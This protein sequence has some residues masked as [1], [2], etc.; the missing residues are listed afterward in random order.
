[1]HEHYILNL[2]IFQDM[3]LW[4]N[5]LSLISLVFAYLQLNPPAS[6]A[7]KRMHMLAADPGIAAIMNKVLLDASFQI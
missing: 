4:K 3:V 6:E 7:L 2:S 1:M 5:K